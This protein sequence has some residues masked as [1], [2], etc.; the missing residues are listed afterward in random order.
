MNLD[1]F[2]KSDLPWRKWVANPPIFFSGFPVFFPIIH[3]KCCPI[4]FHVR[5]VASKPGPAAKRL[6][7]IHETGGN[8]VKE[9]IASGEGRIRELMAYGKNRRGLVAP[10]YFWEPCYASIGNLPL[11]GISCVSEAIWT[12]PLGIASIERF[13][14]FFFRMFQTSSGVDFLGEKHRPKKKSPTKRFS[15][16]EKYPQSSCICFG[17]TFLFGRD[18]PWVLQDMEVTKKHLKK[19]TAHCCW[20]QPEIRRVFPS[21]MVENNQ[22]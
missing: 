17:W 6:S 21:G 20:W 11:L 14:R 10:K 9:K 7:E 13:S 5:R 1:R 16:F 22:T 2:T 4:T 19:A 12:Y 3:G 8:C 15:F 18:S